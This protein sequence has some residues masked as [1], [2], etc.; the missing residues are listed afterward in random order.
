MEINGTIYIF[1]DDE[2]MYKLWKIERHYRE[3]GGDSPFINSILEIVESAGKITYDQFEVVKK[4]YNNLGLY[5][6]L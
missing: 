6:E 5:E 1:D 4:I 2:E 3:N